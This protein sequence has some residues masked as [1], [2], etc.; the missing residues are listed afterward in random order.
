MLDDYSKMD[1]RELVRCVKDR[2]GNW[3]VADDELLVRC[4]KYATKISVSLTLDDGQRNDISLD[5][6]MNCMKQ[7][8]KAEGGFHPDGNLQSYVNQAARNTLKSYQRKHRRDPM[9]LDAI[10]GDRRRIL[11]PSDDEPGG[12]GAL[13]HGEMRDMARRVLEQLRED[14]RWALTRRYLEG[15]TIEKMADKRNMTNRQIYDLLYRARAQYHSK[16]NAGGHDLPEL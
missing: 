14:Y 12:L 13:L 7:I 15:A 2:I 11:E 16:W 3:R 5:S 4:W 6:A 1:D 9:S 8:R 10:G